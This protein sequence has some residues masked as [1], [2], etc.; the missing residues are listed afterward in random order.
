MVRR[1]KRSLERELTNSYHTMNVNSEVSYGVACRKIQDWRFIS[2]LE[3][4]IL[5]DLTAMGVWE[6]C[7]C[8]YGGGML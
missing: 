7:G 6:I 3:M 1:R 5:V 2:C 4:V 8:R